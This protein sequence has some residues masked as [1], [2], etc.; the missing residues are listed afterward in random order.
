MIKAV[1]GSWRLLSRRR[2]MALI[3]FALGN[4]VLNT[5]DVAAI[6]LVGVI[7]AIAVGGDINI[8]FPIFTGVGEEELIAY[9]LILAGVL[10][11]GKT[12]LGV[13]L[14]RTQFRFLAR[15]ETRFSEQIASHVFGGDLSSVRKL[16]RSDL[17]WAILRSTNIA[18]SAVLGRSLI[19]LAEFGLALMIF[20]L[21]IITDW[22]SALLIFFY[23]LVVLGFLQLFAHAK[24]RI[25]GSQVAEGS[26][27][28][29]QAVAD[30][31]SAFREIAVAGRLNFFVERIK[32]A[33]ARVALGG[34]THAYLQAIPRLILE[35][36]LILGAIGLV[37]FLSFRNEGAPDIGLLSVFVVGSLRM[38]S[39]LLPLQ[40]AFM[41]LRY[42][43]PQ[44]SG[45][46][47]IIRDALI[48]EIDHPGQDNQYEALTPVDEK[49]AQNALTVECKALSFSYTDRG[50]SSPALDDISFR[51]EAGQTVAFI[52]PSGA[53][54]S[55]L[56]DLILG[57]HEPSSGE[58]MCQGL[59]PKKFRSVSPGAIGYVPQK[60]GL[61]SGS[62]RENVALGLMREEVDEEALTLALEQAEI[63]DFVNSLPE[64][65]NSTLGNHVDSLSG[66]QIQRIGLARALYSKPRLLVL[67]EATS[68]LDAEVEASITSSLKNLNRET[69]I[70]VVAH[71]LS[72]IQDADM[73]LAME[74]GK[75]IATG[76]F[77]ELRK[78]SDLVQK[79]VSLMSFK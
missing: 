69:T 29:G 58:I 17:E 19:L 20:G 13:L 38:M 27:S 59:P 72:T 74:N 42:F 34:A 2:K 70:L 16:S 73:V 52:G 47:E 23:F 32:E 45:A 49:S 22:L 62:V 6:S 76:S 66:G 46:Q 18:F 48:G 54:K 39:A 75:L 44:A 33:R 4:F 12:L 28:V 5:L 25:S 67:D 37:F 36:A 8:P 9:L 57:L 24:S 79:Y 63:L 50:E 51:V 56:I 40:R 77:M 61:V 55:T 35:L 43:G 30:T 71:R 15:I 11:S 1:T 3:L 26:V 21:F 53:G 60:P 64:G 14:A 65:P 68:A 31:V 78:S 7:G 10:F 41:E